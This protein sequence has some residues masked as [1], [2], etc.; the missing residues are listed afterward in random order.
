MCDKSLPPVKWGSTR[1]LLSVEDQSHL[2]Q[3]RV[4]HDRLGEELDAR[5]EWWT[6]VFSAYPE[7]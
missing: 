5:V 4:R 6:M 7:T 3:E 2:A 1:A